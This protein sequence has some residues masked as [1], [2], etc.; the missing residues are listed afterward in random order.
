MNNLNSIISI[1]FLFL[2]STI[3]GCQYSQP[4]QQ[5]KAISE[6]EQHQRE[7]LASVVAATKYLKYKCNRSDLPD[8]SIIIDVASRAAIKNGWHPL[9]L[10]KL[11]KNSDM[12]YLRLTRDST[13]EKT[14]CSYFNQVLRPF[15]DDCQRAIR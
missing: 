11:I 1:V 13:S 4:V 3:T 10:E 7:Q 6:K 15:I 2:M 9:V 14:K 12:I 8:A 5:Q